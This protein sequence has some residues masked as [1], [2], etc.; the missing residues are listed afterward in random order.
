VVLSVTPAEQV[1]E[2]ADGEPDVERHVGDVEN[3]DHASP[4]KE[5][6]LQLGLDMDSEPPLELHDPL[7]VSRRSAPPLFVDD[8]MSHREVGGVD[9]EPDRDLTP[10]CEPPLQPPLPIAADILID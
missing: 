5:K 7:R 6:R 3:G 8:E 4:R 9:A 1:P 2:P 10:P